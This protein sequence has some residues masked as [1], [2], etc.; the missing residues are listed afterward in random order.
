M[1]RLSILFTIFVTPAFADDALVKTGQKTTIFN[2]GRCHV[3]PGGNPYGS[4]GSTPSFAVMRNYEDWKE[5]FEAFYT[6]PPHIAVTQIE[7]ITEDFDPARPPP[8]APMLL[9][10]ADLEA[11]MAFVETIEP[12][13]VGRIE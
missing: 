11:I 8:M 4:I 2:C 6:E 7:G 9:T 12:K 10:E 5:R 13:D 1:K 3:V